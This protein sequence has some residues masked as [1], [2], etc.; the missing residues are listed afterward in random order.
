MKKYIII[1]IFAVLVLAVFLAVFTN[2][3][4][5]TLYANGLLP[6]F[7]I[8]DIVKMSELIIIGEVD[9]TLP[10]QWISPSGSDVRNAS[11]EE[12]IQARGLFTDSLISID[13]ILKGN[14]LESFVRIR[15]FSG[16]TQKVVWINDTEPGYGIKKTYLLFLVKDFGP[17]AKVDSGDYIPVGT[18]QGV[19]EIVN[20]KA[21]S[22]HEEWDLDEFIKYIQ[23][24]I[25]ETK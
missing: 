10:S 5:V 16:E 11:S 6:K 23:K 20:G 22:K 12:I 25:S 9:S 2:D 24:V 21:I 1:V 13:Q 3:K 15:S 14:I 7:S 17:T 18:Y 4:P 8:V 19:Y